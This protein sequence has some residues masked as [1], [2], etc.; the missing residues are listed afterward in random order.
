MSDRNTE[1]R[2]HDGALTRCRNAF[3][4][5]R[6]PKNIGDLA[7]AKDSIHATSEELDYIEGLIGD[8]VD[9]EPQ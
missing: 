2:L 6:L 1:E 5:G 8:E 3:R 4:H 9:F 7:L